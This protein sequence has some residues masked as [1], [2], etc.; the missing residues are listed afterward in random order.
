MG[1]IEMTEIPAVETAQLQCKVLSVYVHFEWR[2]VSLDCITKKHLIHNNEVLEEKQSRVKVTY[3]YS[4][5]ASIQREFFDKLSLLSKD[6]TF[7]IEPESK[8]VVRRDDGYAF[9]K[10]TAVS[11]PVT[12]PC[13]EQ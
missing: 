6:A 1:D 3:K 11:H 13:Q 5:L 7:E 12:S 10:Y 9:H 4:D 8:K 2:L